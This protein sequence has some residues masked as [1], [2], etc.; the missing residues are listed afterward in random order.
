MCDKSKAAGLQQIEGAFPSEERLARGPAA[1]IECFQRIPCNPCFADCKR[2]AI[3]EF[4]DINDLPVIDH[5]I[6]NGC[7]MCIAK[8]PGLAIMVVDTQYSADE[9]L[10]KIP[11][12]F[13]P[14]PEKGEVVNGLDRDGKYVC[15]V[16]VKDILDS[17]VLDKTPIVSF[18]VHK[19]YLKIVRNIS[20]KP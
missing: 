14:L 15:D 7:G 13:I 6:C 9:A 8:C 10:M 18:A 4:D 16:T 20:I 5:D 3:K 17:K 2:K 19:K 12:E 11:Y 1:I